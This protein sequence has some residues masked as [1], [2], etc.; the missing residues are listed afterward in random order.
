MPTKLGTLYESK[1]VPSRSLA[2]SREGVAD[3]PLEAAFFGA[4]RGAL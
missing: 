3:G 1:L 2:V 4:S